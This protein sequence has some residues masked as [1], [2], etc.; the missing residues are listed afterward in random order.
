MPQS[1][2][3]FLQFSY[4]RDDTIVTRGGDLRAILMVS[5]INFGL[6]SQEE[7][8]ALT[9]AFQAFLNSLDF[10]IQILIHSRKTDIE[11]YLAMLQTRVEA[12]DSEL[13]RVQTEEYIEFVR[14]FVSSANIMT[15]QFFV[16]I[17]FSFAKS[18]DAGI[19]GLV[20]TL[21][22]VRQAKTEEM[23]TQ[24]FDAARTQL[25]QRLD[26]VAQGLH[27]LGLRSTVL[28]TEEILALLWKFYNPEKQETSHIPPILQEAESH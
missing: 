9:Y 20:R 5:A 10:D 13:M 7:Q 8:D 27:Q 6:K 1:T 21:L 11:P 26:F 23:T 14:S 18:H 2:Q 12:A 24:E 17:P 25:T 28:T 3:S 4:I 22:P 15:K 16:T 19:K